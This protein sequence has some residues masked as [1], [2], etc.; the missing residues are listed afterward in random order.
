MTKRNKYHTVRM[1]DRTSREGRKVSTVYA[2]AYG[3]MLK[4]LRR[5]KGLTEEGAAR[6]VNMSLYRWQRR[7]RGLHHPDVIEVALVGAAF[8]GVGWNGVKN[9]FTRGVRSTRNLH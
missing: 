9:F 2:A 8:G 4:R 5:Q 7:E 6:L 1:M 3:R